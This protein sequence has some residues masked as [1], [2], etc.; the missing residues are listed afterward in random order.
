M[1]YARRTSTRRT[2]SRRAA[3]ARSRKASTGR[4]VSRSAAPRAQV[5]RI[6]LQTAPSS[7]SGPEAFTTG[8]PRMRKAVH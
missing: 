8:A 5:V 7:V 6:V 2:S 3:P 1:A 4:R